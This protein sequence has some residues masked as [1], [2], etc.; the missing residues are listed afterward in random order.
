MHNTVH[1]S[2][3]NQGLHLMAKE[4]KGAMSAELSATGV[5][6][7]DGQVT[8]VDEHGVV[9]STRVAGRRVTRPVRYAH[10]HVLAY[11][12]EGPGFVIVHGQ[13]TFDPIAGE[14]V[15]VEEGSVTLKDTSSGIKI[16]FNT[17]GQI[18]H[19]L[20]EIA[21]DDRALGRS[22]I[23]TKVLRA[24]EKEDKPARKSK[25]KPEKTSSK[26]PVKAGKRR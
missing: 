26:K 12:E 5:Y 11:T 7:I 4:P 17:R 6:R 8:K 19:T 3:L 14:V 10:E 24:S 21:D 2:S 25:S 16:T 20:A 22:S 23:S 1:R 15:K 18:A 13:Q 9:I